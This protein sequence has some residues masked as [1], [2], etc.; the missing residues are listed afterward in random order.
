VVQAAVV[1]VRGVAQQPSPTTCLAS[2]MASAW[3]H[4]VWKSNL[5]YAAP[6]ALKLPMV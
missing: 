5:A 6:V 3:C 2:L 1:V 4:S